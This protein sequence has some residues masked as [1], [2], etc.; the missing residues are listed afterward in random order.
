SGNEE[1]Q[2]LAI[3]VKETATEFYEGASINVLHKISWLSKGGSAS[4][5][6]VEDGV[7]LNYFPD[8]TQ[9]WASAVSFKC[10][11]NIELVPGATY[12][13]VIEAKAEIA[14]QF[15]IYFVNSAGEKISGFES[16]GLTKLVMGIMEDYYVYEYVF[17]VSNSSGSGCTLEIHLNYD[18]GLY[19]AN[20]KIAQAIHFKQVKLYS[21]DGILG[22]DED[23]EKTVVFN[24]FEGYADND[25]Y[26]ADTSD[27]IVGSRIGTGDFI[28]AKSELI[29]INGNKLLTQSFSY[30]GGS[31]NGIRIKVNKADIPLNIQY[32]AFWVK[33]DTIEGVN[34]FQSFRYNASGHAEISSS[35]VGNI[36]DLIAGTF[37]YIPVS[38]LLSD[39]T[40][41]SLVINVSGSASGTLY[42]DD[43][44][45]VEEKLIDYGMVVLEDFESYDP[46]DTVVVGN[47]VGG[48]AFLPANGNVVIDEDKSLL[49]QVFSYNTG[50]TNGIRFKISKADIPVG[51]KYLAIF[52][53]TSNDSGINSIDAY[54]YTVAGG[55]AAISSS[56]IADKTKLVKGTYVY[57]PVSAIAEDTAE[58]SIMINVASDASGDLYFDDLLLLKEFKS[59]SAPVVSISP[60]NLVI[61]SGM[62]LEEGVPLTDVLSLFYGMIKITDAEDGEIDLDPTWIDND[63]LEG[64]NPVMGTYNIKVIA[65]DSD[66]NESN[67]LVI[68]ISIVKVINDFEDY[69][70]DDDFKADSLL[71][72]FRVSQ[73]NFLPENGSLIVEENNKYLQ[74]S[75]GDQMSGIR[76]NIS[77]ADL[78][79]AGAEYIGIYVKTSSTT[80]LSAFRAF[81]YDS[82]HHE[83]FI[84]YTPA[85]S[86]TYVYVPVSELKDEYESLS[87]QITASS[88]NSGTIIYDNIVIK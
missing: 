31:T 64:S 66:G 86:G 40:E 45:Y 87:I 1:T 23:L 74:Q 19:L 17:T 79:T 3:E 52:M 15:A 38:S 32:L 60:E 29:E 65:V 7:K 43:I 57:L 76:F 46:E 22:T 6:I 47:R 50:S 48:S 54:R 34:K 69:V 44:L 36:N 21:T 24:D 2:T 56:I 16:E 68:P 30:A 8:T 42:Y 39:T 5:Y 27:N 61:I 72:G 11:R 28:K 55:Y 88:G 80:G 33:T 83:I 70:D 25:A 77:K 62:T 12:K 18:D 14:R 9:G 73:S 63:G 59:G 13:L 58:V 53:K 75:Y 78:V 37:V 71:F 85:V 49:K 67:Q 84:Q 26:Q 41:L 51:I 10:D 4:N 82:T 81:G 20:A 35:V